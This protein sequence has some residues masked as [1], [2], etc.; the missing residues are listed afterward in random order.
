MFDQF[1]IDS[2]NR[3][4]FLEQALASEKREKESLRLML[5]KATRTELADSLGLKVA[6][7]DSKVKI[8]GIS[9]PMK[10]R[11]D[12]ESESRRKYWAERVQKTEAKDNLNVS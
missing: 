12:A 1:R 5:A 8:Q 6:T 9:S 4:V 3:I 10:Q 7:Q 11:V 2:K